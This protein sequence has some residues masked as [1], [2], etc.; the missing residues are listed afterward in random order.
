MIIYPYILSDLMMEVAAKNRAMAG[1]KIT[2][3]NG[4]IAPAAPIEL[5]IWKSTNW[6]FAPLDQLRKRSR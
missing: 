6:S 4:D 2:A 5:K 3:R 1:G